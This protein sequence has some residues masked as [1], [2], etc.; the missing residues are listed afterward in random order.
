MAMT[1]APEA[2]D[3]STLRAARR[4]LADSTR[5]PACAA[6]LPGRQCLHCGIDLAGADAVRVWNLSMTAVNA[7]DE[8]EVVVRGLSERTRSA[9]PLAHPVDRPVRRRE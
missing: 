2:L 5:C 7:L 3:P 1:G 4:L 6:P 9:R 8:R